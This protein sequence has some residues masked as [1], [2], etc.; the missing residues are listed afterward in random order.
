MSTKELWSTRSTLQYS[1]SQTSLFD[2]LFPYGG[3][4][5]YIDKS[6]LRKTLYEYIKYNQQSK[7]NFLARKHNM[8][9]YSL[10]TLICACK[11][12]ESVFYTHE[13]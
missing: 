7:M 8:K 2:Q 9:Q 11:F 12:S 1:L 6:K 10:K 5:I 3:N 4:R 13:Y